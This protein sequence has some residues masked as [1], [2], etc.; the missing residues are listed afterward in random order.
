MQSHAVSLLG[1]KKENVKERSRLLWNDA[2]CNNFSVINIET[3]TRSMV[4][5]GHREMSIVVA[6]LSPSKIP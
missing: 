6:P 2:K 5:K 3:I 4:Y 1:G